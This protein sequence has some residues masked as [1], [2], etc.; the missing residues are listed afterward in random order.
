M[1]SNPGYL[2]KSFLLYTFLCTIL[3]RLHAFMLY[4]AKS[5]SWA[6][7]KTKTQTLIYIIYNILGNLKVSKLEVPSIVLRVL[8]PIGNPNPGHP[9][10]QYVMGKGIGSTYFPTLVQ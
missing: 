10:I 3:A 8:G 9:L 2:L 4:R 6:N 5:D 1:G 7:F